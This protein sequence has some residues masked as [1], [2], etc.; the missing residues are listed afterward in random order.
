MPVRLEQAVLDWFANLGE[1]TG[2]FRIRR[3]DAGG[4]LDG[5]LSVRPAAGGAA[6]PVLLEAKQRVTPR[7]VPGI[8]ENARRLFPKATVVLC[9]PVISPRV[10][11]MCREAGIGY[12]DSAGNCHIAE[13]AFFVHV[14]GRKVERP[15]R[16]TA[17]PFARKSSRI[18]RVLLSDPVRAW[19]IQELA[20]E[21][22]VSIGLA[23]RIAHVLREEAW[24]EIRDGLWH[25]RAPRALLKSWQDRYRLPERRSLYVMEQPAKVEQRIAQWAA[26][27]RS[28]Y[29]LTAFSG[30]WQ[31]APMVR[32]NVM[33]VYVESPGTSRLDALARHLRAK[34][35]D[36]GANLS[37]WVP[38]DD[39]TFYQAR[40]V[41]DRI[42]VS[43][44][45]LYLDLSALRG[46]GE[47]AAQEILERELEPQWST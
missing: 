31:V 3:R 1:Q 36:T 5:K 29:A 15:A 6:V 38:E 10:A 19:Q 43:P 35:V 26:S 21:A 47:E 20:R 33:M 45:Q 22:D 37:L 12:L 28:R 13:P 16:S 8:A 44:L 18:V 11:E 23:S 34:P 25:V 14:E 4:D 9:S 40:T 41:Q 46:R 17:D 42:V 32:H 39:F 24:A 30:A 27:H 7:E 2:A